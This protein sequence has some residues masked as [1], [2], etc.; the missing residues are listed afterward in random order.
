MDQQSGGEYLSDD[1]S[2]N[3]IEANETSTDNNVGPSGSGERVRWEDIPGPSGINNYDDSASSDDE[4]SSKKTR[5][6]SES[7]DSSSDEISSVESTSSSD[8]AP[9]WK[10]KLAP[11]RKR[12]TNAAKLRKTITLREKK[13]RQKLAGK[14]NKKQRA[15]ARKQEKKLREILKKQM[16]EEV[17]RYL[18]E[19]DDKIDFQSEGTTEYP[20]WN[21]TQ[22][23]F[24]LRFIPER[25]EHIRSFSEIVNITT[26]LFIRGLERALE[27]TNALPDDQVRIIL[28][29]P[30]LDRYTS[31]S[32]RKLKDLDLEEDI[33]S[34]F[35]QI[36]QS[37]EQ[38]VFV[39]NIEINIVVC[40]KPK[41]KGGGYLRRSIMSLQRW[42]KNKHSIVIIKNTEDNMCF[43]RA[44]AVSKGYVEYKKGEMP[45]SVYNKLNRDRP[46]QYWHAYRLQDGAG[47]PTTVECGY[48][49]WVK[50]QK[51]LNVKHPGKYS[52]NVWSIDAPRKKCIYVG[53]PQ[54]ES[55]LHILHYNNHFAAINTITGFLCKPYYCSKCNMAFNT[56]KSHACF[57]YCN[58]CKKVK[59][60]APSAPKFQECKKCHC[61]FHSHR[62]FKNHKYKS[63]QAKSSVCDN[64]KDV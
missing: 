58:R 49:E 52:I 11:R 37:N 4:P 13:R 9:F 43:A 17:I 14:E 57:E 7:T 60:K 39:D 62:C 10:R 15:R 44:L 20:Q 24:R 36:I 33:L 38:I 61:V 54:A 48:D 25:L 35:E 46:E 64:L 26:E 56:T 5:V 2:N 51:Y 1:N 12:L 27:E 6:E 28:R 31:I 19:L 21:T 50:F 18:A 47:V 55:Q 42:L 53:N 63:K 23:N 16:K 45:F 3:G 59:C 32:F 41:Q 22:Y 29:N 34:K 8:N 30:T 40:K